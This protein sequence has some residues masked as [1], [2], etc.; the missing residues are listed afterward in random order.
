MIYGISASKDVKISKIAGQL[1]E[2]IKL[3]N[4]IER[5]CLY[6]ESF[7]V[8]NKTKENYYR[9]LRTM[10]PEYSIGI[11]D[12]SDITKIYGKV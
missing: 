8:K 5:L 10:I 7:D 4:T 11:F 2:G 12:N 1:Y 6:L 9:H 3:D